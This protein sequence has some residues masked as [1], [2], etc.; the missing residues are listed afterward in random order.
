MS[1]DQTLYRVTWWWHGQTDGI[2][3]ITLTQRMAG[4]LCEENPDED[5][6][7]RSWKNLLILRR[8]K[9]TSILFSLFSLSFVILKTSARNNKSTCGT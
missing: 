7:M 9:D 3:I 5:F 2:L 1:Q 4:S 8:S 6:P